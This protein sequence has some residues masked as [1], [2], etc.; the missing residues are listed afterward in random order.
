MNSVTARQLVSSGL[1]QSVG[2]HLAIALFVVVAAFMMLAPASTYAQQELSVE[3]LEAYIA[4]QKEALEAV[5]A[6]RDETEK[7]ATEIQEAL[8]EQEA[9]RLEVEAEL[10]AL[11]MER[12]EIDPG[13]FDDCIASL[14]K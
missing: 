6:N 10:E 14:G 3:E 2:M 1:S 8:A 7:K 4:K 13:T 5:R 12:E 11:C 9:R